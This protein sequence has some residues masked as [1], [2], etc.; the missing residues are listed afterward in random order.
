MFKTSNK[1]KTEGISKCVPEQQKDLEDIFS[2][3][4]ETLLLDEFDK[5]GP[6]AETRVSP[7]IRKYTKRN[8]I[9]LPKVRV[10]IK[11]GSTRTFVFKQN[12]Q[13]QYSCKVCYKDA[14]ALRL[15]KKFEQIDV[16]A[17]KRLVKHIAKTV[18]YI[19]IPL[20]N[21]QAA[22]DAILPTAAL[23]PLTYRFLFFF[24]L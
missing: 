4:R 22:A 7:K 13:K 17:R 14:N 5:L 1:Y 18:W 2:K 3:I 9:R 19:V 24:F 20:Y 12:K 10:N 11:L 16:A 15:C 6:I 8:V 23:Y 21:V